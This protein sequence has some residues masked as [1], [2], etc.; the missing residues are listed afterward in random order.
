MARLFLAFNSA[1]DPRSFH[2]RHRRHLERQDF[3]G[4]LTPPT[5]MSLAQLTRE[6]VTVE[7]SGNMSQDEFMMQ[8][9]CVL[10]DEDDNVIGNANKKLSHTFNPVNS[11]GVLHRAFSVFLFDSD[12]R[13]LLQQRAADKITFPNVWTNTCCSH[14]LHGYAPTEV[15]TPEDVASGTVVGSKRAAVRK[16]FQELGIEA[17]QVPLEKFKFLTR[18]HYWAA[19]VVTHG[20][21]SPW[22]EHEIDYM[23]FI[24]ADVTVKPNVEEVKDYKWVT[25]AELRAMM[26]PSTGLLWSPWFRIIAE[27]LLLPYWW[28][29][30][31]ETLTTDRWV[32]VQTIHRFDPT[33][34]HMG[35]AGHAGEWLGVQSNLIHSGS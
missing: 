19:D 14:Q 17:D 16:L 34:E 33:E 15:D 4:Y 31:N 28:S 32:D 12:G 22:G 20:R 35:G 3:R 25:P 5:M 9:E 1:V 23:L 2:A 24:Q 7:W 11:R 8:D 27:K 29:D 26:Q 6:P 21:E 13:L 18:V 30:L 10:V